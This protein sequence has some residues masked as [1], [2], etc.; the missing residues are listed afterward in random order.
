MLAPYAT[1]YAVA[2]LSLTKPHLLKRVKAINKVTSMT[3]RIR[4]YNFVLAGSPARVDQRGKP[5]I[6]LTNFTREYD[7]APHQTF[8]DARSGKH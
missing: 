7:L 5:I 3:K 8:V 4:P 2:K 1:E 6:P